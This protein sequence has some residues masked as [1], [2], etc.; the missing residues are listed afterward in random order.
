[1]V[2]KGDV[3]FDLRMFWNRIAHHELKFARNLA[4]DFAT[5]IDVVSWC[6]PVIANW[7]DQVQ[8]VTTLI[9]QKP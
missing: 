9:A 2:D 8:L 6:S 3:L 7:V 4:R 5:I 1:M